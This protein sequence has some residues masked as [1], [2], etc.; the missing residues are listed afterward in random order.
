MSK[1]FYFDLCLLQQFLQM[2]Q[3][4][5]EE[6]AVLLTNYFLHC[7]KQAWLLIGNFSIQQYKDKLF[8]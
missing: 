1:L 5:E 4:D 3:G 2:L 8:L 6:H 7:G